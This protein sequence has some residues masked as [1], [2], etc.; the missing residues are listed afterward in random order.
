MWFFMNSQRT[1]KADF[2]YESSKDMQLQREFSD[3]LWNFLGAFKKCF[4][5]D[6]KC[7]GSKLSK[8]ILRIFEGLPKRIFNEPSKDFQPYFYYIFWRLLHGFYK[9]FQY[10]FLWNSRLLTY[11][12]LKFPRTFLADFT[13]ISKMNFYRIFPRTFKAKRG[14]PYCLRT[15]QAE[16]KQFL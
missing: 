7:V 2:F 3:F 5:K 4:C 9:D 16:F 15:S 6:W 12:S 13:R 10:V 14:Q 11:I 1:F 8:W